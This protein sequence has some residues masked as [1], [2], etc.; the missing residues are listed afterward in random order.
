MTKKISNAG[1]PIALN[2]KTINNL[3]QAFA[4]GCNVTEACL[5]ANI[6]NPT[7]YK[8]FPVD[9]KI[10]NHF[11][12]LR[13]KPTLHA[14][15]N[16]IEAVEQKDLETSKWYLER[17]ARDEFSTRQELENKGDIVINLVSNRQKAIEQP[18]KVWW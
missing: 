13:D 2:Q 14:R 17:K 3:E 18:K 9:S 10:F 8:Y 6:S 16:V 4:K 7:F 1:R 11:M 12:A 15:F 5:Y